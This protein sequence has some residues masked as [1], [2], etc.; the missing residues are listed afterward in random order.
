MEGCVWCD[1][2]GKYD[3]GTK[4]KCKVKFKL[5]DTYDCIITGYDR[6]QKE[7]D[8]EKHKTD[9]S[10]WL[11][12]IDADTGL[13]IPLNENGFDPAIMPEVMSQYIPVT[14]YYYYGWIGSVNFGIYDEKDE[15]ITIGTTSG[16]DEEIRRALSSPVDE[17]LKRFRGNKQALGSV[18]EI[19]GTRYSEEL[20]LRHP[21]FRRFRPDKDPKEC[22]VENHKH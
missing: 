17:V 5:T 2:E 14:K 15:L 10:K 22:T 9:P 7:V 4:G 20:S 1:L 3:P 11:Y 8:F 18:I 12:W 13:N 19:E 16:M 21:R 6:P